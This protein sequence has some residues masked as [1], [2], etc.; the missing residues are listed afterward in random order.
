MKISNLVVIKSIT[1]VKEGKL[2]NERKKIR[3]TPTVHLGF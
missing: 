2:E 3:I 1:Q